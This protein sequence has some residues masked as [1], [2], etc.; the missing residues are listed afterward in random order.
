MNSKDA[1]FGKRCRLTKAP[2]E[3]LQYRSA[4]AWS[5]VRYKE[6][7][8]NIEVL[9]IKSSMEEN[10]MP[11]FFLMISFFIGVDEGDRNGGV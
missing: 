9:R 6:L 8:K 4:T 2:I 3:V 11:F 7:K 10:R 1:S 5:E